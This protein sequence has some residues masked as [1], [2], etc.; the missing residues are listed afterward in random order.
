[1][2]CN[3]LDL[4]EPVPFGRR[5][6]ALEP[7][8]RDLTLDDATHPLPPRVGAALGLFAGHG[9]G[10][11][12]GHLVRLSRAGRRVGENLTTASGLFNYSKFSHIP[13]LPEYGI[14]GCVE[15]RPHSLFLI[16]WS[17]GHY[18]V[19][20]MAFILHAYPLRLHNLLTYR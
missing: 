16:A 6:E 1:M 18:P 13:E 11:L 20:R 17:Y 5:G 2:D 19:T 4:V 8:G 9:L 15:A 14:R 3:D 7:T 12:A 10:G